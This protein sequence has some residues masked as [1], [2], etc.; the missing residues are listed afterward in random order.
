VKK[1]EP[2]RTDWQAVAKLPIG[3]F[4][5]LKGPV[6]GRV[7]KKDSQRVRVF[8]PAML[9]E[10][11]GKILFL[12][13]FLCD[14]YIELVNSTMFGIS[15]PPDVVVQSYRSYFDQFVQGAYKIKPI[16]VNAGVDADIVTVDDPRLKTVDGLAP[17]PACKQPL[18]HWAAHY[19]VKQADGEWVC[20][21]SRPDIRDAF[22]HY[23]AQAVVDAEKNGGANGTAARV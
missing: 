10:T 1:T 5:T 18:S 6:V 9:A 4:H 19:P 13:I 23:D 22:P 15:P 21:V 7:G 16:I 3:L 8:A 12:P 17:C 11:P 20:E 14:D 2:Q